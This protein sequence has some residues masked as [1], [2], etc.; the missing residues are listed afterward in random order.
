MNFFIHACFLLPTGSRVI[1]H[2]YHHCQVRL[3]V[4][5]LR[6]ILLDIG[7]NTK[8]NIFNIALDFCK[9][10]ITLWLRVYHIVSL[11]VHYIISWI[12]FRKCKLK[13]FLKF[14]AAIFSPVENKFQSSESFKMHVVILDSKLY[15]HRVF[16]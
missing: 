6:C 2:K 5:Q 8:W 12:W 9:D 13:I 7:F 14:K 4:F 16:S 15:I 11:Y 3:K 10:R 1:Y